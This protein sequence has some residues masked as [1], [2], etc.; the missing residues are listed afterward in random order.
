VSQN[1]GHSVAQN[2]VYRKTDEGVSF[3]NAMI[4]HRKGEKMPAPRLKSGE[5]LLSHNH[6][7][8]L[9]GL[10][11][12]P[13]ATAPSLR[14]WIQAAWP[15]MSEYHYYPSSSNLL[16]GCHSISRELVEKEKRGASIRCTLTATGRAIVEGRTPAKIRGYGPYVPRLAAP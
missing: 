7:A 5:V 4:T 8:L 14:A 3:V 1:R 13:D 10:A 15:F 6:A 12:L 16:R 2:R 9:E 11:S